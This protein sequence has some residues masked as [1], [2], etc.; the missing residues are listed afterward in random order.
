MRAKSVTPLSDTVPISPSFG[1][2]LKMIMERGEARSKQNRTSN[3]MFIG[4]VNSVTMK[5]HA[6]GYNHF[7]RTNTQSTRLN[8]K[9]TSTQNTKHRE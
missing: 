8:T 7:G 4:I 2:R 6:D 3:G 1:N 9:Y 5:I